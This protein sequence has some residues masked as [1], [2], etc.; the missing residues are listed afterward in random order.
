[1]RYKTRKK[2]DRKTE[3]NN[4]STEE[5]LLTANSKEKISRNAKCPCGSDKKFKHCCGSLV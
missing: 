5:G 4:K 3:K 2:G 1:M